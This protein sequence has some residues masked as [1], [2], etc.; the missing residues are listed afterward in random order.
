[1]SFND[2]RNNQCEV[3]RLKEELKK[4]REIYE[5]H[6]RVS[7]ETLETNYKK[8]VDREKNSIDPINSFLYIGS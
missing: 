7:E 6:M 3:I 4:L 8:K 5:E 1:M 2:N